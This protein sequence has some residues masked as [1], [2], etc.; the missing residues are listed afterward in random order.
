MESAPQSPLLPGRFPLRWEASRGVVLASV[1]GYLDALGFMMLDGLF[2]NHVTGNI[3]LAAAHPGRESLPEVVMFPVFFVAVVA[4]TILAG[5]ADR[6][7]PGL[8]IPLAL[9]AEAILLAIFLLLGVILF[10]T[11]AAS[12]LL[13][14]IAVGAVGVSAMA[15][16]TVTTRL[17]G[18]LY[19]TNMVTGTMTVLGMDAGALVARLHSGDPERAGA[20]VRARQ[21]ALVVAG[22]VAGAILAAAV[23]ARVHFWAAAVPL[24]TIGLAARREFSP[25]PSLAAEQHGLPPVADPKASGARK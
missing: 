11:P 13:A 10:P 15:I 14:Q 12:G 20:A 21:Y 25:R 3:I 9:V 7:R 24:A 18:H 19:P 16:Q 2:V 5:K 4:G 17:A 23:T 8:G 1:G 6:R 22:F